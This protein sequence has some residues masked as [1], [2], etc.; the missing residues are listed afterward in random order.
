M[1]STARLLTLRPRVHLRSGL[2]RTTASAPK[3][4]AAPSQ[5]PGFAP[6]TGAG[7]LAGFLGS[8]AGMGGGFVAIPALTSS[9]IGLGQHAAHG[10]SLAAVAA[11]GLT[12]A[13]TYALAGNVDWEAVVM[14]AVV[15]SGTARLGARAA[16][17]MAPQALKTALGAFMITVAP[18]V[19]LKAHLAK[20]AKA[21]AQA[22]GGAGAAAARPGLA[23]RAATFGGVGAAAGFLAG[24]FGLGGGA[25]VVPA[26]SLLTDLPYHVALGTSLA[27][28]VPT[29]IV[30][31]HAHY[32]LGNVALRTAFPL[33]VGT[34]AGALVGGTLAQGLP[35]EPLQYFFAALMVGLGSLTLRNAHALRRAAA[36]A[37]KEA[38]RK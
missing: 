29:A 36:A 8:T 33:A 32:G 20:T 13:A 2:R 26:L 21:E 5:E 22:A 37:A 3:K 19:P 28:M 4:K 34:A 38:K 1:L 30:G 14:L 12:G 17:A 6:V 16:S 7:M 23:Q 15:S 35:E 18:L 10:T 24:V 27:A 25:I 9:Y 31:V 11:T